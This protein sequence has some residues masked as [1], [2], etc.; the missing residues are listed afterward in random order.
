MDFKECLRG[1]RSV[2][3]FKDN[4]VEHELIE[5]V[6]EGASYSPSW[7]NSQIVRY[8]IVEDR[9]LLN[10][11]ADDCVM[12]FEHNANI[13]RNAPAVVLVTYIVGRS[14]YDKDGNFSTS[15]GAGWEMFDAGIASQSFSLSAYAEGLGCVILGVFDEDM[16]SKEA[17]IP[18][19]QKLA[20]ILAI[21]YPDEEP[22]MPKRKSVEELVSFR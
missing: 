5:K 17:N 11:L 12:D 22:T 1:R 13:I 2:R 15:K 7:K 19:G 18:E 6:V 3:K 14:G 9:V 4:M 21:G 10:K 16:V 20:A 8:I